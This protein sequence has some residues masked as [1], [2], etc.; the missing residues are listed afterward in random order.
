M[1]LINVVAQSCLASEDNLKENVL[2]RLSHSLACSFK[3]P[4]HPSMT[5]VTWPCSTGGNSYLRY[6]RR[7]DR[8]GCRTAM[9]TRDAVLPT[10]K[11]LG[12]GFKMDSEGTYNRGTKTTWISSNSA[13]RSQTADVLLF[14][15]ETH[16][17]RWGPRYTTSLT[18]LRQRARLVQS[19]STC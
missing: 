18:R 13:S 15:V 9:P 1:G 8:L 10:L 11:K 5:T 17:H 2:M 4:Q 16:A 19:I 3:F 6:R 14:W 12:R 7:R